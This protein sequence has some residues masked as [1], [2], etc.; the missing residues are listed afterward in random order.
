M[1]LSAWNR[2]FKLKANVILLD[3]FL[4]SNLAR[5]FYREFCILFWKI[6]IDK[7]LFLNVQ[8]F[9]PVA[10]DVQMLVLDF[11]VRQTLD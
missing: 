10:M 9:I 6:K 3:L 1:K 7:L 2:S 8:W 5:T 4:E 11:I